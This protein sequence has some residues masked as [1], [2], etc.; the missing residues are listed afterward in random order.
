M[1]FGYKVSEISK[2]LSMTNKKFLEI[3]ENFEIKV[4]KKHN[5]V[6]DEDTVNFILE[7]LTID[8]MTQSLDSFLVKETKNNK[9][10]NIKSKKVNI[11]KR[12][13]T[14]TVK[15]SNLSDDDSIKIASENE[16]NKKNVRHV[17]TRSTYVDLDKYNDRYENI[18]PSNKI[19]GDNI[20]KKQKLTQKSQ[21]KFKNKKSNKNKISESEK[22]L[23]IAEM[24][25]KKK[26]L[27]ITV[28]EEIIVSNL[29]SLLKVTATE[30]IKKLMSLGVMATVTQSVDYDTAEVI[31]HE[32]G[33]KIKKEQV[34]T[35]EERVIDDVIDDDKDLE[36]RS[37][38]VV[39]MGHVD[40]GKTS[41]LDTIRKKNVTSTEAG[42]I[43]Q[44]I[45]AYKV[46]CNGKNITFLDTPGHEAFTSMRARGASITD[47]AILVVAA[48]DGIMPQTVEA[49]NH[50]K[51]AS[52]SMIVAI[53]KIDKP[54]ANIEKIKQELT[55]YELVPEDWGGDVI[56]VGVSAKTSENIDQLLEMILLVAEVKE[57]KANP[58]RPCKGVV[59]EAKLDKR[60]GPVATVLVQN[61][62]LRTANSV[63]AGS[64]MGKIRVMSD[65]NGK[66]LTEAG[67]STPV[68]I[69][70]LNDV[71]EAGDE[72]NV[73]KNEKLARMLVEERKFN[74]K[75]EQFN[76]YKKV[77]L[78]T[79]FSK[80]NEGDMKELSV[81]V[82][83]DVQGSCEAVK[84]SLEKIEN[85]EVRVKVIHSA[86]GAV[87]ESDIMLSEASG[88][89]VIAFNVDC[90]QNAKLIAQKKD[91]EIR[92]YN[93][94]YDAIE[95]IKSAI[96]GMLTPKFR[97]VEIGQAEVRMIYKISSV[98]TISGSYVTLGKITRNAKV[99][100]LREGEIICEDTI[101]SLKRFKD[102]VK[103]VQKGFECG[104]SLEK[105]DDIKEG[106]IFQ[107]FEL[108]EYID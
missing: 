37:P 40:H 20:Q 34:V 35:I 57:L 103:E 84:Q 107:V 61:G 82:K 50:A 93:I 19:D 85:E 29:A 44:H 15:L 1:S 25:K 64:C 23:R 74:A 52:V 83:A 51:A 63:I 42:G 46:S 27:E 98:G 38:V 67:P 22:L 79:L 89:L 47:I 100:L 86:V 77:T 31:A 39:I 32:F 28:G 56:C 97:E 7:R 70:G 66:T 87:T 60:R 8:N 71:P 88:A 95:D 65:E 36:D 99:K 105:F 16:H 26:T 58:N 73:V 21:Q 30:V 96:K 91:I 2:S 6:L 59:I 102:D 94:I 53:N 76:S 90:D 45:G 43:T 11:N 80:I 49:I 3:L 68:E 10:K 17:D 18:A 75:Q 69:T 24:N 54:N 78:E 104:I 12:E 48:D 108:Q 106:D 33:A 4:D 41:L 5:T 62:T 81:I 92:F 55:E 72:L 14:T 101:T 13:E 9:L